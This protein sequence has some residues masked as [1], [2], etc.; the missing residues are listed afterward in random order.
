MHRSF[1]IG[2]KDI[3]LISDA[4]KEGLRLLT[5]VTRR[6]HTSWLTES[7][8][9]VLKVVQCYMLIQMATQIYTFNTFTSF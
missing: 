6:L 9:V 7:L 3:L 2:S 8:K 4:E 1:Y 5:S